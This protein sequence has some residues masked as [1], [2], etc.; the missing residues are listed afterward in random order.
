[1]AD[2]RRLPENPHREGTVP[3]AGGARRNWGSSA[4]ATIQGSYLVRGAVEGN[5]VIMAPGHEIG[6]GF[7]RKAAVDQHVITRHRENDLDQVIS[8]HPELLG[9]GIDA[10]HRH[11][12]AW[13]HVR[14]DRQ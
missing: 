8:R 9:I 11:R 4:G 6:M 14:R 5:S 3:R 13:E 10:E 1:M 12:G 7:L 2:R